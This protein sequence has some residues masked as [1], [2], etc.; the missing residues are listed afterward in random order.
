MS[1]CP[2]ALA[3]C[4]E[5]QSQSTNTYVGCVTAWLSPQNGAHPHFFFSFWPPKPHEPVIP[6]WAFFYGD[7][8]YMYM[9]KYA[10]KSNIYI[11]ICI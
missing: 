10:L 2:I 11:Y 7:C 3:F 1:N 8:R 4:T 9:E 6:P 5:Q